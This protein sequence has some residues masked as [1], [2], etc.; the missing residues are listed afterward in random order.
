MLIQAN[1]PFRVYLSCFRILQAWGDE[2]AGGLL[3]TAQR[4]LREQV[5]KMPDEASRQAFL[6]NIPVN[7]ALLRESEESGIKGSIKRSRL[8]STRQRG[9][10]H[11]QSSFTP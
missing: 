5:A 1:E 4:L 6:R 2:R 10:S 11:S 9:Q 3:D 8:P 7:E